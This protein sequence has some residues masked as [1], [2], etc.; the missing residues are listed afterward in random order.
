MQK[1]IKL[2]E[3]ETNAPVYVDRNE[4][5]II[6]PLTELTM[7]SEDY[8]FD[9]K[10]RIYDNKII[11]SGIN[12][13]HGLIHVKETPP[14]VMEILNQDTF[15]SNYEY[16]FEKLQESLNYLDE[17]DWTQVYYTI[18]KNM[19]MFVG[20]DGTLYF[21]QRD[22]ALDEDFEVLA[23]VDM[24]MESWEMYLREWELYDFDTELPI[25]NISLQS[26]KG[27]VINVIKPEIFRS[28]TR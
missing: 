8:N 16:K 2:T 10:K 23:V 25:K 11:F 5:T 4:I 1:F 28:M 24:D 6:M 18:G 14:R 22:I 3:R 26:I 7:H 12:T 15:K 9:D 17:D 27:F 13:K 20:L 21:N 19:E